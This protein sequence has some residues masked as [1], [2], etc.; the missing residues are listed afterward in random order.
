[1]NLKTETKRLAALAL[2]A[3]ALRAA[4]QAQAFARLP[5]RATWSR[6][7]WRFV[8][9]GGPPIVHNGSKPVRSHRLLPIDRSKYPG[10]KLRAIRR[11][12]TNFLGEMRR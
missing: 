4:A 10:W 12:R 1:M 6:R 3:F 8:K 2:A 5:P 7:R 11:S 9:N